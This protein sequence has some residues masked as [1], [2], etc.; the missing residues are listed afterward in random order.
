MNFDEKERK[1]IIKIQ[2]LFRGVLIRSLILESK[3]EYLEIFKEIEKSQTSHIQYKWVQSSKL[4]HPNFG[5]NLSSEEL[6]ERKISIIQKLLLLN[7]RLEL[8]NKK[9]VERKLELG[10]FN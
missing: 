10:L 7:E 9:I 5:F 8:V 2:A 3:S 6:D 1:S 4:I